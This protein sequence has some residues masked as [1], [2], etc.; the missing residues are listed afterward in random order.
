MCFLPSPAATAGLHTHHG[1]HTAT[2]L[3]TGCFLLMSRRGWLVRLIP[4]GC[5][6]LP[7]P[8]LDDFPLEADFLRSFS[9]LPLCFSQDQ[10]RFPA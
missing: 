7:S 8:G 10:P 2:P 5:G 6:A 1:F 3:S 9:Q 4:K